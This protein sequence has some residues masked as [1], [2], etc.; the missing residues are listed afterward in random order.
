MKPQKVLE[1]LER[2]VG[3][4]RIIR[5]ERDVYDSERT[6]GYVL[7]LADEWVAMHVLADGV[8]LDGVVLMRLHDISWAR[9]VHSDYL[10]RALASLE[11]PRAVFDCPADAT[12]RDLVIAAAGLHPLSAFALGD[13][14]EE[15]LMIGRLL[16][17]GKRRVHH[18]F[19]SADGTW[20]DEIDRWK[21]DQIVSIHIGGRYID[22]L[23]TFG[24]PRPD[25]AGVTETADPAPM[26]PSN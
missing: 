19:I 26:A 16:K 6:E 2:S 9:D 3:I 4:S 24:D 18:R 12:A 20:D 14:G 22:A 17:A 23:A 15:Q 8:H 21:Y 1:R 11:A 25:D 13:E 10:D 5:V 7:A